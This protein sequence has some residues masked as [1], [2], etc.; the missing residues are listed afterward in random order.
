MSMVKA[1][2]MFRPGKPF[3]DYYYYCQAHGYVD[4]DDPDI[5]K[6][7]AGA[8]LCPRLQK[9]GQRCY[10]RLRTSPRST[11]HRRKRR[12]ANRGATT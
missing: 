9:N 1:K 3:F 8:L 7:A 10:V 6:N 11:K 4:K 12:E 2:G 5:H